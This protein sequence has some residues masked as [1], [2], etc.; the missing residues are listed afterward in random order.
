VYHP[1]IFHGTKVDQIRLQ[2][3]SNNNSPRQATAFEETAVGY[4]LI[5]FK[6]APLGEWNAL[7]SENEDAENPSVTPVSEIPS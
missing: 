4:S 3:H 1:R 2:D 7:F 5:V 6:N